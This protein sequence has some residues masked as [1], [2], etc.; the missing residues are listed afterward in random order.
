RV[1]RIVNQGLAGYS[2]LH[3]ENADGWRRRLLESLSYGA[4]L[5]DLS[6]PLAM[7]AEKKRR[8][9]V[10]SSLLSSPGQPLELEHPRLRPA[11]GDRL[12]DQA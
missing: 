9:N 6:G 2:A 11:T 12:D 1:R 4:A 8:G 10:D 5:I 7:E 3:G